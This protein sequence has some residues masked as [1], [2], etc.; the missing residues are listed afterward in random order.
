MI[1]KKDPYQVVN[2]QMRTD[3]SL[4]HQGLKRPIRYRLYNQLEGYMDYK[5]HIGID[6]HKKSS[7]IVVKDKN[8]KNLREVNIINSQKNLYSAIGPFVEDGSTQAVLESTRNWGV[9]YDWLSEH[10]DHVKLANPLKLKVISE[11]K[12]KTD[13]IDAN[14]LSEFLLKDLIPESYAPSRKVR[15][16][17][18]CLRTR[19][20]YVRLRT[21]SKNKIHQIFDLYPD[22]KIKFNFK[23]QT[24]L[25]GKKGSEFLK[26]F[27]FKEEDGFLVGQLL[28]LIDFLN[29]QI[30]S[31]EQKI[32]EMVKD[33]KDVERLQSIPGIGKYFARLLKAEIDDISRFKRSKSLVKYAG[34]CPSTYSS[35]EKTVH[36]RMIK[37]SNKWIRWAVIEAVAPAR[38]SDE[39]FNLVYEQSRQKGKPHNK[40]KVQTAKKLLEVVYKVLKDQRTY[41][42]FN[43]LELDL[44]RQKKNS[45]QSS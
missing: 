3:V 23:P 18:S 19:T 28:G 14:I 15:G 44:L 10:V 30:K 21:M 11:T 33:D 40:A 12:V 29:L 13:K 31:L 34:L 24:D 22:E 26:V 7:F 17:K 39:Y 35:A 43:K 2:L 36:G 42:K 27:P 8:G 45:F 38:R 37:N 16:L 9:M 6:Y 41:K 20:F 32:D 4:S 1:A 5:Y 25:F